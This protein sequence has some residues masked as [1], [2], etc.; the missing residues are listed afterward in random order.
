MELTD[1]PE[2]SLVIPVYNEEA[3]LSELIR[4]TLAA[5]DPM[6]IL[7]EMILVDDGSADNSAQMIREA[8]EKNGGK[9][10]GVFLTTNFGQ[11]AAVTAGLQTSVGKY[12]ITLDADLQYQVL[13][14]SSPKCSSRARVNAAMSS[15]HV[16]QLLGGELRKP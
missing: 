8:A 3:N 7:Y 2:L 10:V 15:F 11:H 5:C 14:S 6:G 1:K 13:I 16:F 12:V 9:V 4:R